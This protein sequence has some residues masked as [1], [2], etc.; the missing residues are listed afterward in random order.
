[1]RSVTLQ[2]PQRLRR[3]ATATRGIAALAFAR[4]AATRW[5]PRH[6]VTVEPRHEGG[7]HGR[8]CSAPSGASTIRESRP[9]SGSWSA[10]GRRWGWSLTHEVLC[11]VTKNYSRFWIPAFAG[12]T[13]VMQDAPPRS[14]PRKRESRG[15]VPAMPG[16]GDRRPMELDARDTD[17]GAGC[18]D[19]GR[20]SR[21]LAPVGYRAPVSTLN[22]HGPP[23]R[24]EEPYPV[25][26]RVPG[27]K[28]A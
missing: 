23:S 21:V 8:P 9:G 13:A 1:M 19:E 3:S 10:S 20:Y 16:W 18:G 28:P 7:P 11:K 15:L 25:S 24:D 4:H 17:A 5:Q 22:E 6:R 26:W 12:M 27:R 2:L 14:F